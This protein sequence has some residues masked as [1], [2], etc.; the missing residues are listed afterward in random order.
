MG[1][2]SAREAIREARK[3]AGLTQ[4]ELAEGICSPRTLSRI[5]TGA[6]GVSP[7][8]FQ[9]LMEHADAPC[10]QFPVFADR[11]DFDCFHA[12]KHAHF[13]LDTWQLDAAFTSLQ[14]LEDKHWAGNRLYYQEWLLLHC[15]LQF[16][17]CCCDHSLNRSRLADALHVT[18]P[19]IELPDSAGAC[20]FTGLLLSLNELRILTAFAQESLYLNHPETSLALC[21]RLRRYVDSRRFTAAE[22]DRLLAELAI[23]Q[24]K[25]LIAE[26]KY[27]AAMEI[28]DFHRHKMILSMDSATPYELTFLTGLCGW[29]TG[30]P[31]AVSLI[32]AAFYSA[33]AAESCYASR[34]LDYLLKETDFP[35]S[36][37][38][39]AMPPVPLRQYPAKKAASAAA[40]SDGTFDTESKDILTLGKL[41]KTL[42]KE[43][44]L[45]QNVLCHGLCNTSMLS[46][47]EN[48]TLLP[49][50]DLAEALLQRLGISERI[51]T[52]W[53]NEKEAEL[54][55]LK[56]KIIHSQHEPKEIRRNHVE[57]L[58]QLAGADAPLYCQL[59]LTEKAMLYDGAEERISGLYEALRVTLPDF[60]IHKIL[61]YRL[62]WA[63]LTIINNIAHE[64]RRTS[65]FNLSILYFEQIME[66]SKVVKPDILLSVH[67][68][69]LTYYMYFHSL[70]VQKRYFEALA[71]HSHIEQSILRSSISTY[72]AYLFFYSQ[73]LGEC[74]QHEKV[75]II[76]AQA[77]Y[78]E[79]FSERFRN[80]SALKK[81]ISDDFFIEIDY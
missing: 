1:I 20:D 23:V 68:L 5:E 12:L 73:V 21:L 4:E 27:S 17:S 41:I 33:C 22:T 28:A 35:V 47:I 43:Q 72:G 81:G 67:I 29:H 51:F 60:N 61:H 62:S 3:N 59:C 39:K 64:Y 42:R 30:A 11:T 15:I 49:G 58:A 52:F 16:R 36:K 37:D 31:D 79:H 80:A 32:K 6:S 63:E 8:T 53:G 56:F 54:Y 13:Y 57:K 7:A 70:Y 65:G 46:K 55:D 14:A 75:P 25:C 9:A 40:F 38:M 76:A 10:A 44:A 77:C 78:I 66:Y 18:R 50:I 24:V 71:L 19:R 74:G 45:P 69:P 48:G 2:R 34:C 26:R